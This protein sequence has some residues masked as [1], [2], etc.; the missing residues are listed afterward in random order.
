MS[1]RKLKF[2]LRESVEAV[3]GKNDLWQRTVTLD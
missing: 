1:I 3:C 2:A